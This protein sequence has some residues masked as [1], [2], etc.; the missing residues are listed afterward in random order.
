M[1]KTCYSDFCRR[2]DAPGRSS[3]TE[4]AGIVGLSSLPPERILAAFVL[5]STTIESHGEILEL[6]P[7]EDPRLDFLLVRRCPASP[8]NE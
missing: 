5:L 4:V 6:T 2:Y 7:L 8:K 3:W 1:R